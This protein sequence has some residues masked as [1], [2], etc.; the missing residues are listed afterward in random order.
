MDQ[1]VSDPPL[2]TVVS[3]PRR[4]PEAAA[5]AGS[6]PGRQSGYARRASPLGLTREQLAQ[7]IG[8]P[9]E[10]VTTILNDLTH[11]GVIDD[12]NNSYSI[13]LPKGLGGS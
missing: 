10:T 5:R 1:R 13:F 3:L 7:R 6:R 12:Q 8:T 4:R 11:Q 9:R 2:E